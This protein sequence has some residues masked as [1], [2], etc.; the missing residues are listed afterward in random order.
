MLTLEPIPSLI[1]RFAEESFT[2]D[3]ISTLGVDWKCKFLSVDG[4]KVK[5]TIWDTAGQE[6]YSSL[7]ASFFR[8]VAGAIFV[9]DVTQMDSLVKV[10]K[11]LRRFDI[12][13]SAEKIPKG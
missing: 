6:K 5:I 1:R 7:I 9:Y 4:M 10:K 2:H 11:W 8:D 3:N 12:D 13:S